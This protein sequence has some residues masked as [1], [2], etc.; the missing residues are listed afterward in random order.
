MYQQRYVY[1]QKVYVNNFTFQPR[2]KLRPIGVFAYPLYAGDEFFGIVEGY[3][4]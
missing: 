3:A 1:E 2:G 4:Q